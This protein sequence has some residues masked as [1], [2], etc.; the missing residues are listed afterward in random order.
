MESK[1][2]SSETE[3]GNGFPLFKLRSFTFEGRNQG[4]K[5]VTG[6]AWAPDPELSYWNIYTILQL[7]RIAPSWYGQE[8]FMPL[9]G[10]FTLDVRR[11]LSQFFRSRR[12]SCLCLG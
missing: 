4:R 1:I 6:L 12:D 7:S 3:I 10:T 2:T 9:D 8:V 11:T 5:S